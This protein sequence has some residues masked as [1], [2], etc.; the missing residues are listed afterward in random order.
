M[1]ERKSMRKIKVP[2]QTNNKQWKL[3]FVNCC[4]IFSQNML[5]HWRWLCAF[6]NFFFFVFCYFYS[7]LPSIFFTHNIK[8]CLAFQSY[9]HFIKGEFIIPNE[10]QLLV[11][12]YPRLCLQCVNMVKDCTM[13]NVHTQAK[14]IVT[15]HWCKW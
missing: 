12:I 9:F 14:A 3:L 6:Y 1:Q 7:F 2:H 4:I 15:N 13:Y 8:S 5:R 10:K 11:A